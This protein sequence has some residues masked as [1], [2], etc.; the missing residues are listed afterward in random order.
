MGWLG[1]EVPFLSEVG[2]DFICEGLTRR[3]FEQEFLPLEESNGA[4][5]VKGTEIT[6]QAVLP[7]STYPVK[8][9]KK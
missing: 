2:L 6:A 9:C 8:G 7:A 4:E 3:V 1:K 5:T